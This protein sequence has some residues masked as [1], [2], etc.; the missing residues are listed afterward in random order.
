MKRLCQ[1]AVV[2]MAFV[3]MTARAQTSLSNGYCE[4]GASKALLSGLPSTNFQMGVIPFC[5]ITVFLHGT[6]TPATIY[7]DQ[8]N[9]P[10]ANPFTATNLGYWQFY[11]LNNATYDVIGSGGNA[12]NTYPAPTLIPGG[13][14]GGAGGGSS[15]PPFSV[16]FA[17]NA[18][19]Q[20]GSDPNITINPTLHSLNVA[21]GGT[22]S[23]EL[24]DSVSTNGV[25]Q[26]VQ[27][28]TADYTY[29]WPMALP[30]GNGSCLAV[31]TTGL[32]SAPGCITGFV[33]QSTIA[34]AFA[35]AGT[36]GPAIIPGNYTGTDTACIVAPNSAVCTTSP[37]PN[38]IAVND[39][40]PRS[41]PYTPKNYIYAS[42]FGAACDGASIDSPAIQ[43][44]I[45]TAVWASN[46][47]LQVL[48]QNEIILPQGTCGIV[49][50]LKFTGFHGS[51][52]GAGNDAT[53]LVGLIG[54][55][56]G[57][58][59]TMLEF[60]A[61]GA[62]PGGASVGVR[63]FSD[64]AVIGNLAASG[65][66]LTLVKILNTS[67]VY[68]ATYGIANLDFENMLLA[69]AD[70][71]VDAEDMVNS[72]FQH[73]QIQNCRVGVQLNG[74]AM[75][76]Y[77]AHN[78]ID[79]GTLAF[80]NQTGGTYG[81]V[82]QQNTKY[83]AGDEQPQGVYFHDN[84]VENWTIPV[85]DEECIDC[86]FDYNQIDLSGTVGMQLDEN[87][88]GGYGVWVDHNTFGVN[89]NSGIGILLG[90][91]ADTPTAG[92]NGLWIT[93]NH[94][95]LDGYP[96]DV[97]PSSNAGIVLSSVETL[98]EAHINGNQCQGQSSCI[99]LESNLQYSEIR[100]NY[101]QGALN[102]VVNLAGAASLN[103][104][105]TIVD[106]NYDSA[107]AITAV[108]VGSSTG[109]TVLTN[110]GS[111]ACSTPT[112]PT[113]AVGNGF[114]GTKTAGS[115]TIVVAGGIVTGITGC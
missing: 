27:P 86:S 35:A 34:A 91:I 111:A 65:V 104:A 41:F 72:Q 90:C 97:S 17:L 79:A 60:T 100:D 13:G 115:C 102:Y 28:G 47:P 62:Q 108:N 4:V 106:G 56:V 15:A 30:A 2:F 32:G 95:Q 93:D 49:S 107:D 67:N 54:S 48:E 112:F 44:A 36:F 53:Y 59:Y 99:V 87:G 92:N 8:S 69:Q 42:D 25:T 19:G 18:T 50:P 51:M 105:H 114:T 89:T 10:L 21:G 76:N 84:S 6:T 81:F 71:C 113:L 14:G 98:A 43:S 38:G 37:N 33:P 85:L 5:T 23:I 96:T 64:F 109:A 75:N 45:D 3:S 74:A 83:G 31:T 58:D 66:Q 29:S 12:P 82:A 94:I 9:T 103:H 80:S 63:K 7:A 1:V 24:G 46:Y 57:T 26:T 20:F 11:A 110:C 101:A 16:Q 52:V 55:W 39:E 73:N 78:T 22:G 68:G 70:T 88:C 77:F 40:R 61:T